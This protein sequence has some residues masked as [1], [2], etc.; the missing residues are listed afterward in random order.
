M[1]R[2]RWGIG[3]GLGL[4][5]LGLFGCDSITGSGGDGPPPTISELP[6]ELSGAERGVIEAGNA[7]GFDLL[8]EVTAEAPGEDAFISPVS[9]SMALAM[10]MGGADGETLGEMRNTLHLREFSEG[11]VNAGYRDLIELLRELDSAV[12]MAVGNAIWY[13]E[14]LTLREGFRERGETYFDASVAALD[15]DRP[16]AA[17]TMN[18]WVRQ[19][20]RD[21]IEQM[22]EAPIDP[23]IVAFL[24]N[25]VYFKGGWTEPFDPEDTRTDDFHLPDGSTET[26]EFMPRD[27]T[28]AYH[29][30]ND[31]QAVELPYGGEAF[32]MTVLVPDEPDGAPDLVGKLDPDLWEEVTEGLSVQRV[33][34]ALPRFEL[35]W[36]M[37]LNDP[38]QALGMVKPLQPGADFSRMFEDVSPWIDEVKQRSFVRVD[39]E[40]TEAAAATQV[41]MISSAPPRVHADRPFIF[42]IRERL[43]GTVLFLGVVNEP[44]VL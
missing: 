6:R 36:G 2:A 33:D 17:E 7:F 13:R 42:A 39:E 43:S 44:P 31:F 18:D 21:R 24:M 11:E 19:V 1:R 10:T 16:G 5:V 15:F 26:A 34:V 27:D 20:T 35:E 23:D 38:L 8:R 40:G 32:A 4:A 25:A 3:P 12:E 29:R 9:A 22:V 30:G 37:S 28:L 41:V 14:G